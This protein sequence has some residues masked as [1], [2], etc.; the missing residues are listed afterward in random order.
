MR[1]ARPRGIRG[2]WPPWITETGA[3]GG[4]LMAVSLA[5][6]Q[7][8]RA[9]AEGPEPDFLRRRAV[10]VRHQLS[11]HGS[12]TGEEYRV[13]GPTPGPSL[14][15][16]N[17]DRADPAAA[18]A[19]HSCIASA[20]R[21]ALGPRMAPVH[22]GRPSMRAG[23]GSAGDRRRH[24]PRPKGAAGAP[25]GGCAALPECRCEIGVTHPDKPGCRCSYPDGRLR[26]GRS[27]PASG[28]EQAHHGTSPCVQPK[29]H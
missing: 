15:Q 6:T 5:P 16:R 8:I 20:G 9:V 11:P 3:L 19:R 27:R 13:T 29:L 21:S 24:C 18:E 2:V 7:A 10:I 17:A 22:S 12:G 1:M 14:L 26:C 25:R 28:G 4:A 23:S